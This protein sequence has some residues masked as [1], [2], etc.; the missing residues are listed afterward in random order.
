M[1]G[2]CSPHVKPIVKTALL[3]GRRR[4]ELLSLKWEQIRYG[5]ISL[6]KTKS[7]KGCQI[8]VNDRLSEV[9]QELRRENQLKSPYVFCG[10]DGK[11]FY[12]VKRSFASARRKAG[13]ECFRFHDLRHTFAS[14]LVMR[15]PSLKAVQELL[16]HASLAMTMRYAH[17]SYELLKDAVNLLN[18]MPISKIMVNIGPK[19]KKASNPEIANPL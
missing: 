5:F 4:E 6:T 18:D 13:I 15:G 11:R 12:E 8:P 19:G 14:Q 1:L 10:P 7:S 9:F 17:L 3:T 2:V 16:G